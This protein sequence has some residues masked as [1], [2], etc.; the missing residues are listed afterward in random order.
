MTG[1]VGRADVMGCLLILLSFLAF[2]RY[3]FFFL[4][5]SRFH[6]VGHFDIPLFRGR[7]FFPIVSKNDDHD[8]DR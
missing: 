7:I 1:V 3:T 2:V 6:L 8:D 5:L 4:R